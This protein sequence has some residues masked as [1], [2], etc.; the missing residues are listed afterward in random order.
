MGW[1]RSLGLLGQWESSRTMPD[2]TEPRIMGWALGYMDDW[3]VD[4]RVEGPGGGG[5]WGGPQCCWRK[6]LPHYE[7]RE[8][9]G[10]DGPGLHRYNTWQVEPR[11]SLGRCGRGVF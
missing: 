8:S 3:E 9:S 2:E 6:C 10:M 11:G 1:G 7:A 5:G 4:L